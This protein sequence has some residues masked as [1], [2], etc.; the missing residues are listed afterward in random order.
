MPKPPSQLRNTQSLADGYSGGSA[1][2]A[3]AAGIPYA[4]TIEL[5]DKGQYGFILPANYV[6]PVGQ[7]VYAGVLVVADRIKNI[8]DVDF[9]FL[10]NYNTE[11][12]EPDNVNHFHFQD[13]TSPPLEDEKTTMAAIL[14][15]IGQGIVTLTN[16]ISTAFRDETTESFTDNNVTKMSNDIN[17]SS[18]S[19]IKHTPGDVFKNNAN[20]PISSIFCLYLICC[21]LLQSIT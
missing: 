19:P 11:D 8:S 16:V 14:D 7:E 6:I 18:N 17:N 2:Y 20:T 15:G 9:S 21:C 5:R 13:T 10:E 1:D 12:I 3:Y 4:Y